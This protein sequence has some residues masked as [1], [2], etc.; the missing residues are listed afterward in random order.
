MK[1]RTYAWLTNNNTCKCNKGF[2]FN[3]FNKEC[4]SNFFVKIGKICKIFPI[5]CEK[6]YDLDN[7]ICSKCKTNSIFNKITNLC[8]C[9]EGFKY[10]KK[11]D[12]FKRSIIL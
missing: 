7:K 4:E 2:G 12:K 1:C 9:L 5:N 3:I 10:S 11:K 6:C 8:D